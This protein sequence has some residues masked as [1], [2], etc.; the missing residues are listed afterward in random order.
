MII[1]ESVLNAFKASVIFC[2]SW[3][4]SKKRPKPET[5]SNFHQIKLVQICEN[6]M[7]LIEQRTDCQ[8]L[9][10]SPINSG[11][12]LKLFQSVFDVMLFQMGVNLELW[13]KR[14]R[15]G[16]DVPQDIW[17]MKTS[18]KPRSWYQDLI[19]TNNPSTEVITVKLIE[20]FL[21]IRRGCVP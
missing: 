15:L 18:I 14:H 13:R 7:N 5:I 6:T 2:G 9:S 12:S 10:S 16:T 19:S 20:V 21:A 3:G 4:S 8:R 11:S 1:F 17:K